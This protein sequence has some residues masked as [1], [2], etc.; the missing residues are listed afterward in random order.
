MVAEIGQDKARYGHGCRLSSLLP[1]NNAS[2]MIAAPTPEI[3]PM[4]PLRLLLPLLLACVPLPAWADITAHYASGKDRLT[5]EVDD[6]GDARVE[7]AGQF[8]LIRRGGTDYIVSFKD[9]ATRVA[10]LDP[11]LAVMKSAIKGQ[12]RGKTDGMQ[13]SLVAA[14]QATVGARTGSL[15]R[16][17]PDREANGAAGQHLAIVMSDDPALAPMA[18]LMRKLADIVLD[19]IGSSLPESSG[20]A[21]SLNILLTKGVPLSISPAGQKGDAALVL[22]DT[23]AAEID[24]KRFELPG[25][26]VTLDKFFAESGARADVFNELDAPSGTP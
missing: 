15:W 3:L 14:G 24:P 21:E 6:G 22:T 7:L 9:G 26:V 11:L 10:E 12:A 4:R 17:G 1:R 5:V 23:N 8:A 20:F 19:L 16:F 13:F 18:P 2:P 25:P